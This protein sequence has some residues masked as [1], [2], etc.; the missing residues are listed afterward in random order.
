MMVEE[1]GRSLNPR[2]HH[3]RTQGDFSLFLSFFHF[4][5]FDHLEKYLKTVTYKSSTYV[6]GLNILPIL[7]PSTTAY[8]EYYWPLLAEVHTSCF[9][10][11]LTT[12]IKITAIGRL[13]ENSPLFVHIEATWNYSM[14]CNFVFGPF[15]NRRLIIWRVIRTLAWSSQVYF[16]SKKLL[17]SSSLSTSFFSCLNDYNNTCDDHCDISTSRFIK[18]SIIYLFVWNWKKIFFPAIFTIFTTFF[19]RTILPDSWQGKKEWGGREMFVYTPISL[20]SMS[21]VT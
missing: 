18:R 7:P 5:D 9:Y 4:P 10:K 19:A 20:Y 3:F 14:K 8:G 21:V 15:T 12:C 16:Q 6:A 13:S 1:N 17:L 11:K 2:V